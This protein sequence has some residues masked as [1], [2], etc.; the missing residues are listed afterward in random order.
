MVVPKIKRPGLLRGG[1]VDLSGRMRLVAFLLLAL[2][3]VAMC[4][5]FVGLVSVSGGEGADIHVTL[6]LIPVVV[7]AVLL[8]FVP[9]AALS[10][11]CG[12]LFCIRSQWAPID[13]FDM[14]LGDPLLSTIPVFVGGVLASGIV[15]CAQRWWGA[16]ST[17]DEQRKWPDFRVL[18]ALV[19]ACL[20]MCGLFSSGARGLI[21]IVFPS[22]HQ[23]SYVVAN[24]L[25][26]FFQPVVVV[27]TLIN[28]LIVSVAAGVALVWDTRR[29]SSRRSVTIGQLFRRWLLVVASLA[30]M[31]VVAVSFCVETVKAYDS[32]VEVIRQQ[33]DYMG[34]QVDEHE[35]RTALIKN[36]ES[37]LVLSKARA[38]AEMIDADPSVAD[39]ASALERLTGI[40]GITSLTVTDGEGVIVGDSAGEGM[41]SFSFSQSAQTAPYMD[42]IRNGGSFVEEPRASV[43]E[44]GGAR[45][46]VYRVFAGVARVDEP[47]IVQVSID[48]KSY[49]EM[50]EVA[51]IEHLLENYA[52]DNNGMLAIAKDGVFVTSNIPYL[53][54]AQVSEVI[55]D[56]A[57]SLAVL[58][59]ADDVMVVYDETEAEFE[60]LQIE[61]HG[62]Y[63]LLSAVPMI[64]AYGA[65]TSAVEWNTFFFFVL[66]AV[67]FL[68]ISYQMNSIVTRS[69]RTTN[70][71]LAR[72][73]EGEL[74]QRVEVHGVREFD[75]LSA[76]IN[77]TVD[78]LK[79]SIAEVTERNARELATA[80]AIQAS[81]LPSAFPPFPDIPFFD[82]YA[83]MAPAREVGGDFYDFFLVD[84][85]RLGIVIADVSDKG[86]PAALFMM[87]A[88][89][90][91]KNYMRTGMDLAQS[92][93]TVNYQLCQEN[94]A[95][96]FVT[97]FLAI[98]DYRTGR[99][100]C[101]NAGHN[102]PLVKRGGS[103]GW[104]RERSGMALGVFEGLPYTSFSLE[105]RKGDELLMY[106]D[107]VTEAMDPDGE[108]YGET[109]LEEFLG[110]CGDLSPR[111]TVR[112]L[113][114]D[115]TRFTRDAEQSDDIT[116]LAL[117]YGVPPEISATLTVPAKVEE[118][119]HVMDFVHD[120]LTRRLCPIAARN[121]LDIALEELFV[122]VCHYAYLDTPPEVAREVRITY[123]YHADMPGITVEI[124]DRG[125]AFDP[126]A[127]PDPAAPTSIEEVQIGGLG[128]MMTKKSV[129]EI[130]YRYED[131]ANIVTF[132]KTW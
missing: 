47:G 112:A 59:A 94:D 107:G 54:G 27:E 71:A 24:I 119:P 43:D 51:S 65:R 50:V 128:I 102:P 81:A 131:G 106:T 116:L 2:M 87:T 92:V 101:V 34:D 16:A 118:L 42:L 85:D 15:V 108:M 33:I 120:E 84:D 78:A 56:S 30:F 37:E 98:L 40:L 100:E 88:K 55:T 76:G 129:D 58:L 21:Y 127:K 67:V 93:E 73:T 49:N 74:D 95:Q 68:M 91:I 20:L 124:A 69:I 53:V 90:Q 1:A 130:T 18:I 110:E 31:C 79:R 123:V 46:D 23:D 52:A 105:L 77:A 57:E 9:G 103:W 80:K 26:F 39:N 12:I 70:K 96:M 19:V 97:A 126:L 66:F 63:I 117:E 14:Y 44:S 41:G 35:S 113:R 13:Y 4:F 17:P 109:G 11:L 122:N 72:I 83:S 6:L 115:V 121:Q 86:V 38:A 8:G 75:K 104:I 99:M 125:V 10:L 32:T 7:G 3:V 29:R 89:T 48:A 5:S 60:Y 64:D 28:S 25:E 36:S 22:L 82:L 61:E 114:H 45:Q 132:L 111:Q 62:E